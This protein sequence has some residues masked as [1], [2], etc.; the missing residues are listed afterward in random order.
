MDLSLRMID[1]AQK[2]NPYND[3]TF[4]HRDAGRIADHLQNDFDFAVMCMVIHE[5]S[6]DKQIEVLTE[7]TRLA[8]K[9]MAVDNNAPL[10]VNIY[11]LVGRMIEATFGRDHHSNSKAFIA[12][13]GIIGIL[14]KTKL[15]SKITHRLV[16]NNNSQELVVLAP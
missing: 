9:T 1:F 5:L 4:L 8:K 16:F 12:A 2:T 3:V 13:G 10:P 6:W 15:E 11:G 14:Q 7:L